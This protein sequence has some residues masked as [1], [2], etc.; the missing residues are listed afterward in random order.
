MTSNENLKSIDHLVVID[1]ENQIPELLDENPKPI[2]GPPKKISLWNR[3]K[4]AKVVGDAIFVRLVYIIIT[5]FHI[6]YLKILYNNYLFFILYGSYL[7][8]IIDGFIV[9]YYRKVC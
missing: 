6:Y 5:C 4:G 1:L 3:I 2:A 9:V 7:L 8:I